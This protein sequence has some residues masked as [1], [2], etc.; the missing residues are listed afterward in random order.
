MVLQNQRWE[1]CFF[2]EEVAEHEAIWPKSRMKGD[3]MVAARHPTGCMGWVGR[4][5]GKVS[6][7]DLLVYDKRKL[8]VGHCCSLEKYDEIWWF[9]EMGIGMGGGGIG[10]G[11]WGDEDMGI[12]GWNI[13]TLQKA[14]IMITTYNEHT[15]FGKLTTQPPFFL[16]GVATQKLPS[17][18]A[19]STCR[20]E[21]MLNFSMNHCTRA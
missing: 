21:G 4:G 11:I 18:S 15:C 16:G 6:Q 12:W 8:A 19:W 14:S 5:H 9:I 13:L 10:M 20:A 17:S 2:A 3:K 7:N 1:R